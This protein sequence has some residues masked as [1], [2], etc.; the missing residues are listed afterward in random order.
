MDEGAKKTVSH[1]VTS[2]EFEYWLLA[3]SNQLDWAFPEGTT[4]FND[5]NVVNMFSIWRLIPLF[6]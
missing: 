3:I 4:E 1:T 6:P 5:V 2:V